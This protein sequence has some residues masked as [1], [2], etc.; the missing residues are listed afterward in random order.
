MPKM[1]TN[2]GAAKRLRVTGSG[3]IIRRPAW[4]AHNFGKKSASRRARIEGNEVVSKAD[5]GRM[6]RLLG[7]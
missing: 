3:K 7:R 5:E 4:N 2:K 1:K 6:R